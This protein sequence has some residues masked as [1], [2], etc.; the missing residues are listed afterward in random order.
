M[1]VS[2]K[3]M[4]KEMRKRKL[5][6]RMRKIK[7]IEAGQLDKLEANPGKIKIF[8][9]AEEESKIIKINYK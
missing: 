4:R 2:K 5:R 7:V 1:I 6:K 8:Y 3:P 9:D